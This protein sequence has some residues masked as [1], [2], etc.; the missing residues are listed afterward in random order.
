MM[1]ARRRVGSAEVT[2]VGLGAMP[3]SLE[4]RPEETEA[5]ATIHA[6][7]DAGVNLI[8]T[9]DAYCLDGTETGHN[10]ELVAR[11]VRSWSG[12]ADHV[13]IATKGGHRRDERGRWLVDGHPSYLRRACEASLRRLNV[14]AIA[15]YQHHR[16]DPRVP[17]EESIGA[18]RQLQDEGKIRMVGIGNATVDQIR[19]AQ[20]LVEV[21]S[22]Q[23]QFS[24]DFTSSTGEV[25]FCAEQGI[26]FLAWAPLGGAAGARDIGRRHPAFAEVAEGLGASLQQVCLAWVLTRSATIIPIPGSRRPATILNSIGA[27]R[28]QLSDAQRLYLDE[29]TARRGVM[30]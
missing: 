8:D 16:P 13:M 29:A 19:I 10:E 30:S 23:N 22:V 20:E 2:A 18:L 3:L 28:L 6:A 25:D 5:I 1:T 24:P 26:A 4:G 17:Y 7:L 11:A 21:A 14:E 15:L 9:A 12:A 27:T